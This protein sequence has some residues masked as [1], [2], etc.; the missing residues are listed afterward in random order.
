MNQLEILCQNAQELL[1]TNDMVGI[2]LHYD[3][4]NVTAIPKAFF[5]RFYYR[6]ERATLE[7][8]CRHIVDLFKA[9]TRESRKAKLSKQR[10]VQE[11][12]RD[13]ATLVDGI[14]VHVIGSLAGKIDSWNP[15]APATSSTIARIER[16][17]QYHRTMIEYVDT[18]SQSLIRK[19]GRIAHYVDNAALDDNRPIGIQC[20][21]QVRQ[22]ANMF[23][24]SE[25]PDYTSFF[26]Y[27]VNKISLFFHRFIA[28]QY[29]DKEKARLIEEIRDLD[30]ARTVHPEQENM[31]LSMIEYRYHLLG[32]GWVRDNVPLFVYALGSDGASHLIDTL[33]FRDIEKTIRANQGPNGQV[34][35]RPC[36]MTVIGHSWPLGTIGKAILENSRRLLLLF[37]GDFEETKKFCTAILQHE[38]ALDIVNRPWHYE[39]F[40]LSFVEGLVTMGLDVN[41]KALE[42]LNAARVQALIPLRAALT[43]IKQFEI[44]MNQEPFCLLVGELAS[45]KFRGIQEKIQEIERLQNIMKRRYLEEASRAFRSKFQEGMGIEGTS[46]QLKEML[47]LVEHIAKNF[48]E[49][50]RYKKFLIERAEVR[51]HNLNVREF[52]D[53]FFAQF[54]G[55]RDRR[56]NDLAFVL[57]LSKDE[58]DGICT[59]AKREELGR[60][61]GQFEANVWAAA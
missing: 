1:E 9:A 45:L 26:S 4:E 52:C 40:W 30:K 5:D 7:E 27:L 8:G 10:A 53:E 3:G 23:I 35:A 21:P 43:M 48:E 20:G 34:D 18:A 38:G 14:V 2:R 36:A 37:A 50:M 29:L 39:T 41:M 54:P 16:L 17:F 47:N 33:V 59:K 61:L 42:L 60:H 15:L 22:N 49:L 44:Q 24:F 28:W 56:G 46:E 31:F 25:R 19:S 58:L 6:G 57:R 13:V 32:P 12:I 55:N 51:K 11:N